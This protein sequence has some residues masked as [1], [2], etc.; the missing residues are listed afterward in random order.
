MNRYLVTIDYRTPYLANS[1][2]RH[3]MGTSEQDAIRRG[4]RAM[5]A[6]GRRTRFGGLQIVGGRAVLV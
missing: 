1:Y 4:E 6:D 3:F 2:R 5:R